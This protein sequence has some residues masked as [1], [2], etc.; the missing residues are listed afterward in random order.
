MAR[1]TLSLAASALLMGATFA[2]AQ[3]DALPVN[4]PQ[5]PT[6]AYMDA[7]GDGVNDN[8]PD[9][10]GD[11]VINPL[12]DD[13]A[14]QG[15]ARGQGAHG[16][17]LDENGDGINDLA[18]DADGDGVPNH[19]DADYERV[20]QGSAEAKGNGMGQGRGQQVTGEAGTYAEPL[21]GTG[22]MGASRRGGNGPGTFADADGDGVNDNAPDADGDGV[23]NH[24][25][26]DYAP[27][28]TQG[29]A[30]RGSRGGSRG[31]SKGGG[32]K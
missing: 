8:A 15:N 29:S 30:G 22:R 3:D 7:D 1:F 24:L 13:Y 17:F 20:P 23:I 16:V 32:R 4:Q 6:G 10:D 5:G 25:D 12:D 31:G 2:A 9:T 27:E 21:N 28:G 14:P 19:L 18:P 26:D 11:G